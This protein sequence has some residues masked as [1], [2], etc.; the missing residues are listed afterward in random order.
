MQRQDSRSMTLLYQDVEKPSVGLAISGGSTRSASFGSGVLRQLL[1]DN[2]RIDFLSSVS[3]GGFIAASYVDWKFREGGHDNP[4]WHERYFKHFLENV[5]MWMYRF[6]KSVRLGLLDVLANIVLPLCN[7]L[8]LTPIYVF[9]GLVLFALAVDMVFGQRLRSSFNCTAQGCFLNKGWAHPK[10]SKPELLLCPSVLLGISLALRV[11]QSLV[12]SDLEKSMSILIGHAWWTIFGVARLLLSTVAQAWMLAL[13]RT[14]TSM[15][16]PEGD[17]TVLTS[18]S[19]FVYF[20]VESLY[21]MIAMLLPGARLLVVL[22]KIFPL[23][24]FL[25]SGK[26]GEQAVGNGDRG[27]RKNT[28]SVLVDARTHGHV[29]RI[30][31]RKQ[32]TP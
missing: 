26:A 25:F 8:L 23:P 17:G 13:V 27:R 22:G 31:V 2:V 32:D 30:A 11:L 4:E 15:A 29:W 24:I 28:A 12:R 14:A 19:V 20:A 21:I 6:D 9:N 10:S 18:W 1:S 16:S 5:S 7:A 3:G